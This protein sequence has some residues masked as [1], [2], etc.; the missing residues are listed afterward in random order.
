MF[1]YMNLKFRMDVR[2]EDTIVGGV[3]K[4]QKT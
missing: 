4:I 1:E 2:V 3:F